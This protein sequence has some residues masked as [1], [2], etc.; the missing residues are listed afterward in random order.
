MKFDKPVKCCTHGG[1]NDNSK[2]GD[3]YGAVEITDKV[4]AIVIMDTTPEPQ[5]IPAEHILVE[6]TRY[7]SLLDKLINENIE[8]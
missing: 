1:I 2:D 7:I 4:Y 8:L 5:L 6:N 3:C